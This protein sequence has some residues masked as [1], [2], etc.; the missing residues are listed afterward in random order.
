L[1]LAEIEV[2]TMVRALLETSPE[3]RECLALLRR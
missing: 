3:G 2:P 1:P